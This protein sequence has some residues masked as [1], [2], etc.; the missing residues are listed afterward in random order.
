V[1]ELEL[2]AK[3]VTGE[4]SSPFNMNCVFPLWLMLYLGK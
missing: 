3:P 1:A 2:E 4:W